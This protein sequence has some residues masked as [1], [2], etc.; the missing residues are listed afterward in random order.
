MHRFL[1]WWNDLPNVGHLW[2]LDPIAGP[3]SETE[4]DRIREQWMERLRRAFP[5]TD[6]AATGPRPRSHVRDV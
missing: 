1:W 3:F 6:I 2:L 5:D 4:A